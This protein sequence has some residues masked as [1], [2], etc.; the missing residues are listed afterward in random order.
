MNHESQRDDARSLQVDWLQAA[1][2]LFQLWRCCS[3]L[4]ATVACHPV[5]PAHGAPSDP[6][7]WDVEAKGGQRMFSG[8]PIVLA[9]RD[10]SRASS[11]SAHFHAGVED[12]ASC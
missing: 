4:G 6:R 5:A 10:N 2:Q 8:N 3:S 11:P 7:Q 1:Q 9:E 12:F